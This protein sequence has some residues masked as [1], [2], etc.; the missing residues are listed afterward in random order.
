M[1][2]RCAL[3]GKGVLT[4]NNVSHA[5]NKTR[6]RYLPNLQEISFVSDALG[7]SVRLRLST[8][9][10]RT[11]EHNGGLDAYLTSV[12]AADLSLEVRRLKKR[13]EKR[14]AAAA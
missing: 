5:N 4:G 10:I 12:S 2:R 3:T 14:L 7:Q 8:N 11:I 6:R 13:I 9:A 1:A